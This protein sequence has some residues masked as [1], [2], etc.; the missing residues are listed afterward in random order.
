[1]TIAIQST[2]DPATA[3]LSRSGASAAHRGEAEQAL[4]EQARRDPDAFA[5]LY[6][7]H[8]PAISSYVQRRTGDPHLSDDLVA[9]VFLSAMRALP[10][11]QHR[12]VPLRAWL[13]RI[14]TN[15]V[16]R[17][18]RRERRT[19]LGRYDDD[20]AAKDAGDDRAALTPECARAALL[21]IAPRYQTV[22]AMHYFERMSIEQIAMAL[23]CREGTVKSRLARGRDAL[24]ARLE[25]RIDR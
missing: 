3:R 20:R 5:E 10:R 22:L 24:R 7:L 15:R 14:A 9:D 16:N 25:R 21:A 1:M 13:M 19:A 8:A 23:G 6:R 11:Y 4:I 18:A 17:W 12:G 2:S